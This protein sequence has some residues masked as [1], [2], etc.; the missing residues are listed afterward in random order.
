M[1]LAPFCT[2]FLFHFLIFHHIT[3]YTANMVF[4]QE[5]RRKIG[6]L[7]IIRTYFCK[8]CTCRAKIR[9]AVL[10][11]GTDMQYDSAAAAA[12][13]EGRTVH[14]LFDRRIRLVRVNLD[15]IER[16]ELRRAEIVFT[17]RH[18]AVDMRIHL[19]G[20]KHILLSAVYLHTAAA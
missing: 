15:L 9:T 1:Y 11:C 6:I 19:I 13:S 17:L 20:H 16:A 7:P 10:C 8:I 14:A 18:C 2:V 3:Y 12:L 4:L 5:I